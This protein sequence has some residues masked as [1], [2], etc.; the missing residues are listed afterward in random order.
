MSTMKKLF[1]ILLVVTM[2]ASMATVV[3]AAEA[4][5]KTE[6][7]MTYAEYDA[8][9]LET[10]VVIEAFVQG[11]QSWWN[12][13]A[14]V[15]LQDE[16]GAYFCYNMACSEEDYAK[17]EEKGKACKFEEVNGWRNEV[18]ANV[19]EVL[20]SAE[21]QESHIRMS[22]VTENKETSLWNRL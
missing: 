16:D 2:L 6:G 9:A 20:M 14:T 19:T 10:A 11:K 21:K 7:V 17:F 18:L 8:A 13:T 1:A 3:S 22:V 12:D 15:Y 5:N 4:G